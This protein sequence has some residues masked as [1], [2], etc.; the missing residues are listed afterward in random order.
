DAVP[1][2]ELVLLARQGDAE[3]WHST[4]P[5][6]QVRA[7]VPGPRPARLAWEQARGRRAA[8]VLEAD[9]WHGPHYTLPLRGPGVPGV[10]TVHDLPSPEPREWHGRAKV[11]C[12]GGRIPAAAS[13]AAACV[14]VSRHTA[15]RLRAL[16]PDAA[17]AVVIHHGI[18]HDRFRA[19]GDEQHD[20]DALAAI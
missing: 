8:A 7:L 6:S 12:S 14:C 4:A 19:D 20:L 1:E 10:V 13:R 18:D 11:V 15:A 9:L 17:D 2:L 5:G 16:V 3:R